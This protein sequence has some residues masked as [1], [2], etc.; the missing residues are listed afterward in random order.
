MIR[1]YSKEIS[2]ELHKVRNPTKIYSA[3]DIPEEIRKRLENKENKKDGE[4]FETPSF[5]SGKE[6]STTTQG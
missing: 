1:S 3:E 2:R 6:L 5:R 4:S